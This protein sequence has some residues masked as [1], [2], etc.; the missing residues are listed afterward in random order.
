VYLSKKGNQMLNFLR[1]EYPSKAFMPALGVKKSTLHQ[2]GERGFISLGR[3]GTGK[4][5]VLIGEEVLYAACLVILSKAGGSPKFLVRG[6]RDCVAFFRSG[7]GD[8]GFKEWDASGNTVYAGYTKKMYAVFKFTERSGAI[9]GEWTLTDNPMEDRKHI[10][11][12]FGHK[13]APYHQAIYLTE[14]LRELVLKI[15][16]RKV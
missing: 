6:L 15:D 14:L 7:L 9:D 3:P 5:V 13:P 1:T 8:L 2:W 16:G 10:T 12:A 4:A 11:E